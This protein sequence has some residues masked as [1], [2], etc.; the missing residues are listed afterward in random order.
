MNNG[1]SWGHESL[2]LEFQW[3]PELAPWL[4]GVRGAD[5][6]EVSL[7]EG[8]PLVDILSVAE[9]HVP[10]SDRL[11]H[12]QLGAA[13]RYLSHREWTGDGLHHL[14]L[15]LIDAVHGVTAVLAL[16]SPD[17]C[18]AFRSRVT[19]TN[20]STLNT[21]VARSVTT[22][23]TY[24]GGSVRS[25][26]D[27]TDW[28]LVHGR[29]DWLAEGRWSTAPVAALLPD[30]AAEL[31]GHNPRGSHSV[32]STGSWSTGKNLPVASLVSASRG[33]A[34][35][36][37]IEH[38]G[39]WRWEIGSDNSDEFFALSGPTDLD[40]QWTAVLAPG[41]SFET[42]PAT[43]AVGSDLTT[44]IAQLTAFRRFARRRHSDELTLPA[45]YN[46][47]M[48]TV[49]GDP[50][51]EKLVPLIDA[52]AAVGA[53]VF[54]IDAGWYDDNHDW[55][56]SV[57]EWIPSELRFAGGFAALI[58]R[59]HSQGMVPGLWLE[60][61]VVGVN[62]PVASRL[63]DSAFLVRFGQ[64][65]VEH[66]RYHLDLRSPAAIDHINEVVDRLVADFGIGYFKL[67]YNINPGPGTDARG[68]SVGAGMLLHNRAHLAWID[69]VLDRHPDLIL[70]NCSSGAMRMDFALLSRM[71]LQSTSDQQDALKYPPIAASAP[72]SMLPEQ[73]ASWSYPQPDMTAEEIGFTL[74]SSILGRF[75]LSGWIDH[76]DAAQLGMV[77]AAV[78]TNRDLV[79]HIRTATPFWP[80]G[81]PAWN[82]PW[83]ALGLTSQN[84]RF[85]TIWNRSVETQES[86]LNFPDLVGSD[87]TVRTLFPLNLVEWTT[88]WD[89]DTGTL[90]VRNPTNS[91]GARTFHLAVS[92][93]GS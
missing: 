16:S 31:T 10:A 14:E 92:S 50:T 93:A 52:A 9:G 32:V 71:Q 55:W 73:A 4:S 28:N 89:R 90:W 24:L 44:S 33:F 83:V 12:T 57:G 77:T 40:H 26:A 30:L 48:N 74:S 5:G 43:I 38:N 81:L 23:S 45:V 85:L 19:V 20:T 51:V 69:S 41:D 58:E 2:S 49:S 54:C 84:S 36:W 6:V 91:V 79:P 15:N 37:E 59:I 70:E 25:S 1:L 87:L 88:R 66:G 18:S 63:P 3:S 80:L 46:D 35:T 34:W 29:S 67:D 56:D 21:L 86:V 11:V 75:F 61:E 53:K 60:P 82:A 78:Q 68:D 39:A 65:V 62:S 76:M 22:W 13:L 17:G 64:R 72:M 7:G 47:Y 8:L 42:V 27:L